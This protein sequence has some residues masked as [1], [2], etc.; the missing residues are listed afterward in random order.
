[1]LA[2]VTSEAQRGKLSSPQALPAPSQA[3]SPAEFSPPRSLSDLSTEGIFDKYARVTSSRGPE[4]GAKKGEEGGE[5][6]LDTQNPLFATYFAHIRL[7]IE[8]ELY[9]PPE[10]ERQKVRGQALVRFVIVE[11]GNLAELRI[12]DPSGYPILDAASVSAIRRA[13]PFGPFPAEIRAKW[14]QL[15]IRAKFRFGQ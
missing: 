9:Y 8:R 14:R 15:P 1:M 4:G 2:R 6:P 12:L 3:P 5:I 11:S 7:K 13:S 10:A